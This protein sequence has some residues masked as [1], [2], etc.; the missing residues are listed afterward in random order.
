MARGQSYC[1]KCEYQGTYDCGCS[2]ETWKDIESYEGYYQV[3]SHGKI[4]SFHRNREGLLICLSEDK[5]GYLQVQLHKNKKRKWFRV[6]RLVA[7]AFVPNPDNK[8]I[9]NHKNGIKRDNDKSNLEWVTISENTQ[10]G[11]DKL[12]RKSLKGESVGTSKLKSEDVLNI[13]TLLDS[14]LYSQREIA[15][16]TKVSQS[17]INRIKNNKQWRH[18]K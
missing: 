10:H 12:N 18:L 4:K 8:P 11:F 14:G 7:Q 3:S 13:R 6:H 17:Q 5:D 15:N 1:P 9:P 16:M 2:L